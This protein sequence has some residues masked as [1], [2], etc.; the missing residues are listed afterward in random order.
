MYDKFFFW[1]IDYFLEIVVILG[2]FLF[3]RYL[4]EVLL[5]VEM[6]VNLLLMLSCLIVVVEFLLL[7][8]VVVF[9]K[10]FKNLLILSVFL[11]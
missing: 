6:W 4:S 8:M 5:L 10:V 1:R 9:D 2:N 11:V 7:M 3:L